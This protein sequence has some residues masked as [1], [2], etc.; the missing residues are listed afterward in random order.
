MSEIDARVPAVFP[1]RMG[2]YLPDHPATSLTRKWRLSPTERA[3]DSSHPVVFQ[4]EA[5]STGAQAYAGLQPAMILAVLFTPTAPLGLS[6]DATLEE[7]S[8]LAAN[9]SAC[10]HDKGSAA[11]ECCIP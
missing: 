1:L 9:G 5:M 4:L 10:G 6:A 7:R 3:T 11:R 2:D 8:S